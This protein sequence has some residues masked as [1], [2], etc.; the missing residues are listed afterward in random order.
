MHQ[1]SKLIYDCNC[2]HEVSAIDRVH[3]SSHYNKSFSLW[4]DVFFDQFSAFILDFFNAR[5]INF[6]VPCVDQS[7]IGGSTLFQNIVFRIFF[8]LSFNLVKD[9]RQETFVTSSCQIS[10]TSVVSE[11]FK[12]LFSYKLPF[13]R[14]IWKFEHFKHFL[15][16]FVSKSLI[17]TIIFNHYVKSYQI[18]SFI[19]NDVKEQIGL[20]EFGNLHFN[21]LDSITRVENVQLFE[22]FICWMSY[23]DT[24]FLNMLLQA[25]SNVRLGSQFDRSKNTHVLN[26]VNG[27]FLICSHVISGHFIWTN[28]QRLRWQ[29]NLLFFLNVFNQMERSQHTSFRKLI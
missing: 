20:F 23:Y 18:Q 3:D 10:R 6:E 24:K 19:L 27:F 2:G 11:D 25:S 5:L 28:V 7:L 9:T 15:K 22:S 29:V 17:S 1:V 13:C 8:Q 16:P 21:S 12:N 26:D 4:N 14:V